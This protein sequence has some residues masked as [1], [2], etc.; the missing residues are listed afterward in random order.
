M[1]RKPLTH[2][3]GNPKECSGIHQKEGISFQLLPLRESW[4]L[5]RE[6]K[7]GKGGSPHPVPGWPFSIHLGKGECL[8]GLGAVCRAMASVDCPVDFF[9]SAVAKLLR[10]PV[11]SSS[12]IS[13]TRDSNK[14]KA[15]FLGPLRLMTNEKS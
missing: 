10:V 1:R 7:Y 15:L 13:R 12:S 11:H 2:K 3:K 8:R 9:V 4:G 6:N 14:G 5:S